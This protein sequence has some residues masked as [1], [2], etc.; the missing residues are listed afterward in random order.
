MVNYFFCSVWHL[1][2]NFSAV[3]CVGNLAMIVLFNNHSLK[4]IS[5]ICKTSEFKMCCHIQGD[6]QLWRRLSL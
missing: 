3:S 5:N 2:Y 4:D 6:F 1:G